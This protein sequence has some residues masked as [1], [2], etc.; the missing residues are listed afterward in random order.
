MIAAI[1]ACEVGFWVLLVAGLAARYLLRR[2]RLS[3]VLL[4]S[5]PLVDV[6][7]LAIAVVDL[8]GGGE[9]HLAHGLAAVY[10]GVSIVL[11]HR[12]IRWADQRAHHRFGGGPPPVRA[13]RT[14]A[15]R[16]AHERRTWLEHLLAY[17]ATAAILSL[18]T[19]LVGDVDRTLP[20]WS[21]M[22]PWGLAV[23]IDFV[24][25]FSYTLFPRR[26]TR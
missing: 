2:R 24:I 25:S 26:E 16:A 4:W 8:R 19:L 9:A 13:P 1:I 22:R 17:A 15:A 6:A 12:M 23:V 3:T 7:L 10:L 11:G 14:G 18:F 5:V 21:V 20:L